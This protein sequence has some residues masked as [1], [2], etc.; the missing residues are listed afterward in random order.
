[1]TIKNWMHPDAR[2]IRRRIAARRVCRRASISGT[3]SFLLMGFSMAVFISASATAQDGNRNSE[4][5]SQQAT[6]A[7]SPRMNYAGISFKSS[8]LRDPFLNPLLKK[9]GKPQ[10][11]EIDR[12][13]PPPGIAGTFIAE[14]TLKGISI[15]ETGRRLAIVKGS[16]NRAYFLREGDRLF[17][18]YLKAIHRDSITLIRERKMRSGKIITQEVTKRLRTP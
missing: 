15:H 5:G 3:V 18:G 7:K 10:D 2:F 9:K 13:V 6:S 1:M 8:N 12:G 11:Q 4:V 17:D 16:E 14:A